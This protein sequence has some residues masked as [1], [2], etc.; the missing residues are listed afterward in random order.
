MQAKSMVHLGV[1]GIGL[2]FLALIALL[3]IPSLSAQ[4]EKGIITGVVSDASGAV[5]TKAHVSLT[6]LAT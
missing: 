6:N 5:L 1:R 2:V 4:V 3:A